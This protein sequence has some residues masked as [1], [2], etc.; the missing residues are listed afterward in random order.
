[1]GR[2]RDSRVHVVE[3]RHSRMGVHS[4][5]G[6]KNLCVKTSPPFITHK[7]TGSPHKETGSPHKETEVR[8]QGQGIRKTG[9]MRV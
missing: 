7:E 2:C 1:M 5:L 4:P 6:A 3:F 9:E 8:D